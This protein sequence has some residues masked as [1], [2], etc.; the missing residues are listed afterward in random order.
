MFSLSQS[1]CDRFAVDGSLNEMTAM[2]CRQR[3]FLLSV[4][5]SGLKVLS[6]LLSSSVT[7][8]ESINS[9]LLPGHVHGSCEYAVMKL[10]L[11]VFLEEIVRL[12]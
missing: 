6:C 10:R 12:G 2:D 4:L 11:S 3:V 7:T 9:P 5:D 8:H 1:L